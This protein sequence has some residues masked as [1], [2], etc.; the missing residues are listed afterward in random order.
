MR[1]ENRTQTKK[2]SAGAWILVGFFALI[3]VLSFFFFTPEEKEEEQKPKV[4]AYCVGTFR[5]K[6]CSYDWEDK[7]AVAIMIAESGENPN[8]LG[9]NVNG[10]IDFSLFQINETHI[11]QF[12]LVQL[13]DPYQNIDSAYKIWDSGDGVE[14]N[15]AGDW[16]QWETFN[17]GRWYQIYIDLGLMNDQ[18]VQ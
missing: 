17:S 18:A 10:T 7:M 13:A 5:E 14:G 2:M 8:A 9:H 3:A 16:R 1:L 4:P 15:G 11:N 12:S 6:I